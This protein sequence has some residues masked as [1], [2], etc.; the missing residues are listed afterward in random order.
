MIWILAAL[1]TAAG[2]ATVIV[3]GTGTDIVSVTVTV[4]SL[5]SAVV[6]F[7]GA[8]EAG[9]VIDWVTVVG[10]CVGAG[11]AEVEL[12][13]MKVTVCVCVVWMVVDDVGSG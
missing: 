4:F 11:W 6:V 8:V 7:A 2:P 12:G 3:V 10:A 13:G 5:P 1:V 9:R